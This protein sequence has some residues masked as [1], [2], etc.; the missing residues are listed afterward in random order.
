MNFE[1]SY[2]VLNMEKKYDSI[3]ADLSRK[4]KIH[5]KSFLSDTSLRSDDLYYDPQ[6]LC[7]KGAKVFSEKVADL[8]L[9]LKNRN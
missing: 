8:V 4:Y 9:E 5:F 7:E 2:G 6:H 1:A 3:L